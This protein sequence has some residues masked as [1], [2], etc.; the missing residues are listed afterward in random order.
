MT[1]SFDELRD[2]EKQ[3]HTTRHD[4]IQGWGYYAQWGGVRIA[5][6]IER[7][8]PTEDANYA[9]FW[10]LDEKWED[11]E[12]DGYYYEVIDLEK[13]TEP[14]TILAYEMN[15]EDLPIPH[16]GPLRLRGESILGYKMAKWVCAIEFV[17][18]Y[19]HIGKGQGGWRDDTLNYFPSG[20]GL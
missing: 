7:C 3:S 20:A 14:M 6:L 12:V 4:C 11:P 8:Q 10:T 16:G 1:L 15:G 2:F 9:V 5:D 19:D 18:D 13:A 17:E